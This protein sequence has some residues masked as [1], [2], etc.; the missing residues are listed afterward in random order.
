MSE[1]SLDQARAAK[2]AALERFRKIG[3]VTGVGVT[4]VDGDYAVK[5]NLSERIAADVEIP[6]EIEGVPVRVEVTG[7]IR[8]R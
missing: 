3:N 5:V 2:G 4:R 6:D 8:P 7:V 1:V